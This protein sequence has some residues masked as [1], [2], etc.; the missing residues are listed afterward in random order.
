MVRSHTLSETA[1]ALGQN[2]SSPENCV[3]ESKSPEESSLVSPAKCLYP[4]PKTKK[5]LEVNASKAP[6]GQA[7]C[8]QNSDLTNSG[9]PGNKNSEHSGF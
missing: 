5:D 1:I 2:K 6:S 8:L 4:I 9:I 3:A 7:I